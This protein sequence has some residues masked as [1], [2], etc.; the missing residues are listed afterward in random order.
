MISMMTMPIPMAISVPA[1]PASGRK[2]FPGMANTPQPTMQPKAIAH[3]SRGD[4]YL[5]KAFFSSVIR[6][7]S[8]FPASSASQI[9]S[10]SV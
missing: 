7:T 6:Q 5:S 9:S 10:S 3:T 8:V 1:G 4:R 2:V